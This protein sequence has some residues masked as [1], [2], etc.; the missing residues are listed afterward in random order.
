M[1]PLCVFSSCRLLATKRLNRVPGR[2][3]RL[4]HRE[5]SSSSSKIVLVIR[6]FFASEEPLYAFMARRWNVFELC[7]GRVE[8]TSSGTRSPFKK[9]RYELFSDMR[10]GA[11]SH[12]RGNTFA[13]L[14]RITAEELRAWSIWLTKVAEIAE[15]EWHEWLLAHINLALRLNECLLKARQEIESE[16]MQ[17]ADEDTGDD[18][19]RVDASAEPTEDEK[20]EVVSYVYEEA[21]DKVVSD[22]EPETQEEP[23]NSSSGGGGSYVGI[24]KTHENV[25]QKEAE[26]KNTESLVSIG[27]VPTAAAE[28]AA[29]NVDDDDSQEKE[30]K[31]IPVPRDESEMLEIIKE[32]GRRAKRYQSLYRYWL[33]TAD[34]VIEEIAGKSSERAQ[35]H[36][37]IPRFFYLRNEPDDVDVGIE[38][39]DE[40]DGEEIARSSRERITCNKLHLF[41]NLTDD[42]DE[43]ENSSYEI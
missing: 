37:E 32:F 9:L 34:R 18:V 23:N 31:I 5:S 8:I 13:R 28:L 17:E 40:D 3:R 15:R 24:E 11:Q 36:E 6:G 20:S 22:K 26:D 21:E 42:S 4:L 35:A 14:D 33:E 7:V 25:E 38:S 19:E 10:A 16:K 29:T 2:R 39:D 30:V 1:R 43:T 27:I 41:F 12:E